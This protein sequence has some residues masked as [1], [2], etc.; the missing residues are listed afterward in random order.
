MRRQHARSIQQHLRLADDED[1]H[2][3]VDEVVDVRHVSP[4]PCR[5][6]RSL[7]LEP[8]FQPSR[9]RSLA[10][11]AAL[12]AAHDLTQHRPV[13]AKF[14]C[15]GWHMAMAQRLADVAGGIVTFNA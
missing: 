15:G 12:V 7:P 5:A 4:L 6:L 14:A 8:S 13:I 3:E 2:G 11:A 1:G 10:P 9:F